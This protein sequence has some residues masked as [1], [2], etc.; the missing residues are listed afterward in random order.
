[1]FES[2]EAS[3]RESMGDGG[4]SSSL[5][6]LGRFLGAVLA[7]FR[8]VWTTFL[9]VAFVAFAAAVFLG[10]AFAFAFCE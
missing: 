5:S 3:L 2:K 4:S 1:V 9:E 10:A 7:V 6:G 8:V